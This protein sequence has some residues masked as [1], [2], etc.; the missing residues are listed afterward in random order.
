MRMLWVRV[1]PLALSPPTAYPG[2]PTANSGA[3]QRTLGPDC[4]LWGPAATL[5]GPKIRPSLSVCQTLGKTVT[6]T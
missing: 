5:I 1:P 2:G 3:R 6:L 4:E